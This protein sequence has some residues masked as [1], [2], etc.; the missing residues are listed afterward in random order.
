M[1]KRVTVTLFGPAGQLTPANR[2]ANS[3]TQ[4]NVTPVAGIGDDAFL[5]RIGGLATHIYVKK[6]EA[7]FQPIVGCFNENET[8]IV[9]ETLA[10]DAV[11]KL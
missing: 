3:K 8:P 10:R 11:S 6:G 9:E 5:R 1:G 7:A 4:P 2:F